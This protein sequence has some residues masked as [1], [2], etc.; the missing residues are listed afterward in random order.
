MME[1]FDIQDAD[2]IHTLIL[3]CK[4]NLQMNQLLDSRDIEGFQKVS[5]VNESLRKS[6]KFTAAQNKDKKSEFVNSIGELVDYCEKTGGAIPEYKIDAP[7]DI[8]DKVIQDLKDYT[9]G[10]IYEDKSLAKQIEDFLKRNEILKQQKQDLKE[11]KERGDDVVILSDQDL[12]DYE[13]N[14]EQQKLQDEKVYSGDDE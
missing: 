4:T 3:V 2:T 10:L 1:S 7:Q 13:D 5:R 14:L 9:K 8:I 6:A 11:A 12:I